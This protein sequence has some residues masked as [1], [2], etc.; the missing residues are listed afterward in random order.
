MNLWHLV[1]AALLAPGCHTAPPGRAL[2]TDCL[3]D[4]GTCVTGYVYTPDGVDG[5]RLGQFASYG[6]VQPTAHGLAWSQTMSA[7]TRPDG[8]L[9]LGPYESF[10]QDIGYLTADVDLETEV[11]NGYR[12]GCGAGYWSGYDAQERQ[13]STHTAPNRVTIDM[14]VLNPDGSRSTLARRDLVQDGGLG[15]VTERLESGLLARSVAGLE[16]RV[17]GMTPGEHRRVFNCHTA[18]D[19]EVCDSRA[20]TDSFRLAV[21]KIRLRALFNNPN[22]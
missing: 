1:A 15:F 19:R 5:R 9:L 8:C 6:S 12:G 3:D 7:T 2:E 17:C 4:D 22:H 20:Y 16:V 21:S 10:P 18:H 14:V 11:C 13:L